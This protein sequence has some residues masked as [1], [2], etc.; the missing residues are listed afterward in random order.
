M[1]GDEANWEAEKHKWKRNRK[2]VFKP[3]TIKTE[4][5]TPL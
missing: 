3:V 4:I 2:K 1:G 5:T